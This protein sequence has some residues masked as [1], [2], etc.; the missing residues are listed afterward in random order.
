MTRIHLAAVATLAAFAVA[1]PAWAEPPEPIRREIGIAAPIADVW[2]AWTTT[3]G[4]Q[5]FFAARAHIEL[6]PRGAYDVAFKA[7]Y[8]HPEPK[9][10]GM[11]ILSYVPGEM[12]SF[13]WMAPR[14]LP[15]L[16]KKGATS[17]VVVQLTS[18][19]PKTTKLVLHHLGWAGEG[20]EWNTYRNYFA[21]AWPIVL[22]RLQR[23][24]AEGKPI[25][26]SKP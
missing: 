6:A 14:G 10:E 26:F 3:A 19:G 21:R 16:R 23:R 18:L 13:E 12:I 8:T 1:T 5:S 11:R 9:F 15:K 24:F 4:V 2:T 17:F 22:G 20:P 7:D 25:D